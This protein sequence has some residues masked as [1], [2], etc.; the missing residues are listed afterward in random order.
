MR[1]VYRPLPTVWPSGQRT[2]W[3]MR[4]SGY[5]FKADWTSTMRLL[6][7]ELR[8][9]G[10]GAGDSVVIEA[11]YKEHEIRLDGLPRSNAKPD[12]PGIVISFESKH[13]PLRYGCDTFNDWKAN[14]RAIVL[15]LEALRAVDR[16]G[17]TKRGEQYQGWKA[18]PA[19]GA[20]M[21]ADAA[22]TWLR[23]QLEAAGLGTWPERASDEQLLRGVAKLVHPDMPTGSREKWAEYERVKAAIA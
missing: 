16:Y 6:E 17:V 20:T 9:L 10:V 3:H 5:R 12:D 18:L 19:A 4:Q 23:Q 22:R 11:G 7:R 13:G 1:L 21:S 14:L 8:H 2:P 15:A